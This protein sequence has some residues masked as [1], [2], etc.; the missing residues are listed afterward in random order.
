MQ[1]FA[2]NWVPTTILSGK[3]TFI[4]DPHFHLTA[5]QNHW[6]SVGLT[7]C[8][9]R[10]VQS[11]LSL[12]DCPV[13]CVTVGLSSPL[14]HCR[15]VQSSVSLSGCPV[16]CDTV[17]LSSPLCHCRTVQSSVSLSDCPVLYVT[18]GLSS[19]LCHCRALQ[20]SALNLVCK[21]PWQ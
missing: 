6:H 11:S 21:F 19:P 14:C 18:V 5:L 4:S 3:A 2:E 13:L 12:S 1:T 17:G 8:H 9:C 15:T 10:A 16:L 7:V 20:S